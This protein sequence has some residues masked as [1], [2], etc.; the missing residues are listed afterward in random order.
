MMPE[1]NPAYAANYGDGVPFYLPNPNG[2]FVKLSDNSYKSFSNLNSHDFNNLGIKLYSKKDTFAN[3]SNIDATYAEYVVDATQK[4]NSVVSFDSVANSISVDNIFNGVLYNFLSKIDFFDNDHQDLY[5]LTIDDLD[6]TNN[7]LNFSYSISQ[8]HTYTFIRQALYDSVPGSD[9]LSETLVKDTGNVYIEKEI[10]KFSYEG[11][12]DISFISDALSTSSPF[13][14][15]SN[16]IKNNKITSLR[17]TL[18]DTLINGKDT[19]DANL[20]ST[21][22]FYVRPQGFSGLTAYSEAF[23]AYYRRMNE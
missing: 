3:E 8:T 16:C 11:V 9:S 17:S 10:D 5:D 23:D 13:I 1:L 19:Q 21:I 12:T 6:Y 20:N 7:V 2:E 22:V 14:E 4:N 15:F 18:N